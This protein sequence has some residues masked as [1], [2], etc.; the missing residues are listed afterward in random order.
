MLALVTLFLTYAENKTQIQ[1][2]GADSQYE[3]RDENQPKQCRN[4]IKNKKKG[5]GES[6]TR[7]S[8]HIFIE[9]NVRHRIIE[10]YK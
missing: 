1:S 5:F 6:E 2:Y 8:G 4:Q 7:F 9:V 3:N 10:D